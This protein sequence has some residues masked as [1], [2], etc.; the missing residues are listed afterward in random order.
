MNELVARLTD[1]PVVDGGSVNQTLD[2]G[3][4]TFPLG[5]GMYADFSHD[6]DITAV[7]FAMGVFNETRALNLTGVE[8]VQEMGGY[9]A[10]R[11]VP[12]GARVEV[13]KM[14]CG[15]AGGELVRVLVNGRVMP[16]DLCEGVDDMGRCGLEGFV[17]M[18]SFARDGGRWGD[19][20]NDGVETGG[21]GLTVGGVDNGD[22]DDDDDDD[23]DGD[24]EAVSS[25]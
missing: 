11:T 23:D 13:E 14:V 8:S 21:V 16:L 5:R 6:N 9:S 18:L 25:S 3:E 12:F 2:A 1:K 19:C 24:D 4:E 17:D 7:L 20:S 22:D 15:G 10:A